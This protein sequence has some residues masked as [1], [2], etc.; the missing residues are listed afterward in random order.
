[1]G[2][3]GDAI[4]CLIRLAELKPANAACR[5]ELGH[6]FRNVG[7]VGDAIHWHGEALALQPDSVVLRLNHLFVL[8]LVAESEQQIAGCRQRCE[9]GL[10]QLEEGL[11]NLPKDR[12]PEALNTKSAI[13]CHPFYLI[14]H[15]H[16]DRDL[17]ERYRHASLHHHAGQQA[18]VAGANHRLGCAADLRSA[19][20]R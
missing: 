7:Y 1:V 11:A 20:D 4:P 12:L 5:T 16:D 10:R 15:N 9:E 6:L 19:G 3:Y 18:G 14:Y 2:R 13:V 17:L 8:P